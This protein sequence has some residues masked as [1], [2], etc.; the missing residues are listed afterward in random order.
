M[1]LARGDRILQEQIIPFLPHLVS[2]TQPIVLSVDHQGVLGGLS[3][4]LRETRR[5]F[6]GSTR[7]VKNVSAG[8]D[9]EMPGEMTGGAMIETVA[10]R[11]RAP[12]RGR[13]IDTTRDIDAVEKE[14][15]HGVG[16]DMT[17]QTGDGGAVAGS[18][19]EIEGTG[20]ETGLQKEVIERESGERRTLLP[21]DSA[22]CHSHEEEGRKRAA[23]KGAI[24]GVRS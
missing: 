17:L 20:A 9:E 4:K 19:V 8:S 22:S 5:P 23:E 7:A 1:G 14:L 18:Q 24:V 3:Q 6:F 16:P 12:L 2:A 15:H 10:T 13:D 21:P 11:D